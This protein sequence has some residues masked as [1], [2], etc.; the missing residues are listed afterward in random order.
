MQD[1]TDH[2]EVVESIPYNGTWIIAISKRKRYGM[3]NWQEVNWNNQTGWV[4]SQFL[5]HDPVASQ[6]AANN[7]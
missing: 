7:T 4:K 3:T 6:K 2:A 5:E 1:P